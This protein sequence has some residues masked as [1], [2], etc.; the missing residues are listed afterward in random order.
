MLSHTI[1]PLVY[2]DTKTIKGLDQ[3]DPRLG[4]SHPGIIWPPIIY[5]ASSDSRLCNLINLKLYSTSEIVS[6]NSDKAPAFYL[7]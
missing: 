3:V 1:Y 6:N 5:F 2:P 7:S 4:K